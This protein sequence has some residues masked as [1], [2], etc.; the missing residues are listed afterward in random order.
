MFVCLYVMLL[1]LDALYL[2]RQTFRG[3]STSPRPGRLFPHGRVIYSPRPGHLLSH[4]RVV[5]SPTAGSS[6]PPRP[7]VSV[8]FFFRNSPFQRTI[9]LSFWVITFNCPRCYSNN[10]VHLLTTSCIVSSI[11]R[12][13]V[14]QGQGLATR[15][16]ILTGSTKYQGIDGYVCGNVVLCTLCEI[17]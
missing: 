16:Y 8:L 1:L 2:G 17:W 10:D 14:I 3:S 6:T 13:Y 9:E 7:V 4:G 5:Y 12:S 15:Y 11:V